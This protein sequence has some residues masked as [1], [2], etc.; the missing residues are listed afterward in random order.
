MQNLQNWKKIKYKAQT[1][2][3]K[4]HNKRTKLKSKEV[5]KEK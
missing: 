5:I 4:Q 2:R 3:K 1:N